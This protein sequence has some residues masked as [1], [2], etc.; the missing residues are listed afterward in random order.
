MSDQASSGAPASDIVWWEIETTDPAVFQQFH[1][2]LSGWQFMP[3]FED[4]E[5]SADYWLVKA[6]GRTIG[7]LQR[8]AAIEPPRAGARLYVEVDDLEKTLRTVVELGGRVERERTELGGD[9][10]WFATFLDPTG[11]SFG[12]WT[13][14]PAR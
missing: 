9:D 3:A 2:E 12:L 10:R 7:G 4:T 13:P 11:V 8:A 1:G 6:D 14:N 5:L